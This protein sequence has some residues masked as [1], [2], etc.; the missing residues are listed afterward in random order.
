MTIAIAVKVNDGI[1]LAAD[2]AATLSDEHGEIKQVYNNANKIINL[3]KGL[4]IGFISW[5]LGGIGNDSI[6]TLLKDLRRRFAGLDGDH[7]EWALNEHSYSLADVAERA[8]EFLFDEY[9]QKAF[10]QASPKPQ[11]GG[12]VAGYSAGQPQSEAYQVA[13]DNNGNCPAPKLVIPPGGSGA[14]WAGQPEALQRLIRGVSG[15]MPQQLEKHLGI[16][17]DEAIQK[18]I[19]MSA[20]LDEQLVSPAMPI[21]D[22]IEFAEFMTET[23]IKYYRF[24]PGAATVGGPI[25]IA[26]ITKHE[27]FK[28]VRRKYYY[29]RELNPEGGTD[30]RR[31]GNVH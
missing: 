27:G 22:A 18:T 7:Q 25:E 3:C 19:A 14:M 24:K 17:N 4:P 9:Y 13:I 10:A 1:V 5:G 31:Q 23:T 2:S 28:W 11:F 6:S 12:I 8:R 30:A 21:Q 20:E 15:S 26:A 16:A 29:S